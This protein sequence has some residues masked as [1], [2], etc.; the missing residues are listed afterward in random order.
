MK[1]LTEA[2]YYKKLDNNN[3]RCT[4]CPHFCPIPEDMIG[5]C[6]IRKN[7]DGTLFALDD[8]YISSCGYDPIEKK[9]LMNYKRASNIFSIGGFGCNLR[10]DF[11]QNFEILYNKS[12]RN[13]VEDEFLLEMA[14]KHNS[15]GIA[16][17]YNEPF[18]NYEMLLRLA[19]KIKA[20][21]Q[22]NIIVTNGFINEKPLKEILPYIDAMNIDLKMNDQEKYREICGADLMPVKRTIKLAHEKTHVEITILLI[23]SLN[24]DDKKLNETAN[25]IASIDKKIP[26]HLSRYFPNFMRNDPPTSIETIK[27]AYKI[28]KKYLDYVYLG[29]V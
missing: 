7:I 6:G 16:Y 8:G 14:K 23:D 21:N 1:K 17:T 24:T 20:Q 10:C 9:P 29:N 2:K 5:A 19:K 13:Y 15:I 25:W 28:F 18:I 22:D 11:C 27:R 3:I 26:V 12:L 4:L